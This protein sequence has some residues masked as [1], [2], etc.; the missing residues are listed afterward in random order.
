MRNANISDDRK[1]P[2]LLPR[3]HHITIMIIQKIHRETLHGGL[4]LALATLRQKYWVTNARTSIRSIIHQCLTCHRYA[5][6]CKQQLMSALPAARVTQSKVFSHTGVDYAGPFDRQL[7]KH[8]GR[9]T[10]KGFV[11]VFV[12]M[13]TK[14]IHPE[15]ASD[16]STKTFLI[17][18]KRFVCS[19][20]YSDNGCWC[21]SIIKN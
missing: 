1:Y 13:A 19:D 15:L 11:A 5:S 4:K 21:Q 20:L 17:A 9:G 2:V 8:Q 18:F 16:L 3:D 12:C 14:A 10:Y 6:H 7:S